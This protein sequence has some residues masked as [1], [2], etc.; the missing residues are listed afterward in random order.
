MVKLLRA[1]QNPILSPSDLP[2]EN[3]LV[4]NP[5]AIIVED[6]IYLI[7][8]AMGKDDIFSRLGLATSQDGIHFSRKSDP[9]Y[10]GHGRPD[11]SLGI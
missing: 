3:M 9:L 11:E 4:F 6:V 2:W 8:R 10:Y 7:Y 5:G 1:S